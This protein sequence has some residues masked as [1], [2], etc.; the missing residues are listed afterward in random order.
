MQAIHE[1]N[2]RG[3]DIEIHYDQYSESPREWDNLGTMICF[4]RRYN[5]GDKHNLTID[6]AKELIE[7]NN[8]ISLPLYL[9]DHSGITMNTTGFSCPWDSGQVGFIYVTKE[10]IKQEYNAKRISK[11]L[12]KKVLDV[13]RCE[14]DTYDKYLRGEVFG[15]N[16]EKDGE[17][18]DS[19][20]G[21][22]DFDYCL[23]EAKSSVNYATKEQ[24]GLIF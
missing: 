17:F 22:F 7:K 8:V 19:C 11:K 5:L 2:Y 12:E 4:H 18:F 21:F 13:L 10:Q 3:Y 16:V 24:E 15:F 6:A 1:E 9:Y 23:E 14:V 20:W